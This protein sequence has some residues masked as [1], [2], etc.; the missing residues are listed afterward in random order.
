EERP[1][2]GMPGFESE[3]AAAN[4]EE[5]LRKLAADEDRSVSDAEL[6]GMEAIIMPRERP[7]AFIRNDRFT[8]L[9]DPWLHLNA[10]AYHARLD[11]LLPSAGRGEL[12]NDLRT[13]YGGRGFVVG[14]GLLMTNRHVARLFASGVGVSNLVY[15]AGDAAVHFRR[16]DGGPADDDAA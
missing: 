12:P 4:A 15:S 11:G 7:V 13:P 2:T 14:D 9:V 8:P 6:M 1:P 16:E 5:G 10:D 3:P